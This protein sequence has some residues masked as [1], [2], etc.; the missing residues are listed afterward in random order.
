MFKR[1]YRLV[2]ATA[3]AATILPNTTIAGG[4]ADVIVERQPVT[5]QDTPDNTLPGWVLPVAALVILGAVVASSDGGGDDDEPDAPAE[6]SVED[7]FV[8]DDDLK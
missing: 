6:A 4:L 2:A 5:I 7:D 8:F 3:I 1:N